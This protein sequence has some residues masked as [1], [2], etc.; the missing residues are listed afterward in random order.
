MRVPSISE[1]IF[2]T[3]LDIAVLL[4][5]SKYQEQEYTKTLSE[6]LKDILHAQVSLLNE[7]QIAVRKEWERVFKFKKREAWQYLS[8]VEAQGLRKHIAPLIFS[9]DTDYAAKQFDLLCLLEELSL[10]DE[11]VNGTKPMEKI[12][13]IGELLE[14]KAA[15]PEVARCM[16]TI[17]EVQTVVFWETIHTNVIYGL[18]NLER[19]REELRDLVQ[20]ITGSHSETFEIN[21]KDT[22]TD[23][24][25]AQRPVIQM[26]YRQRVLE[27]L[28]E[29]TDNPVL[30]KIYR[31]EQLTEDDIRELERIFWQELGTKEEYEQTY[32]RQERYRLCGGKIAVFIR[33]VIG[34]D[35]EVAREKYI[36]MIQGGTLTQA[37]E[38]Y[39]SD[40]LDY[41]CQNGD[42]SRQTMGEEP[43][44][45]VEWRTVFNDRL[46]PLVNY[47]DDLHRVVHA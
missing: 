22:I 39:L 36:A 9:E 6:Q 3:R 8:E 34:L 31:I 23:E 40:I 43:F 45:T 26:S 29:H 10:I 20:Y 44:S 47:V 13:I 19:V 30:Q 14:K 1:R 46:T 37:Q 38:E 32:L 25:E 41:V 42:I 17:R 21:L 24:G 11:T 28:D 18:D 12:R 33:S 35:R 7:N 4:Q 27:Y 15:I 16:P 2:T 5:D